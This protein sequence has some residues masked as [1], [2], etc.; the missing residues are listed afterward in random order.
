MDHNNSSSPP[1]VPS[2]GRLLEVDMQNSDTDAQLAT[3]IQLAVDADAQ[4]IA[5]V[6][7]D[8]VTI[9]AASAGHRLHVT[10]PGS[11]TRFVVATAALG[12]SAGSLVIG[13]TFTT[14]NS[15]AAAKPIIL[16]EANGTRD[17]D[18]LPTGFTKIFALI[19]ITGNLVYA[20]GYESVA[21]KVRVARLLTTGV[22]DPAFTP[23]EVTVADPGFAS[24]AL[25]ADGKIIAGAFDDD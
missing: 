11:G 8:T 1:A 24:M 14:Y 10:E 22:E 19:P 15:V 9:T 6:A 12:S 2:G 23:Y 3:K 17:A 16:I 25:Q 5:T 20:A 4:F 21:G 7:S 18:Y 13:G